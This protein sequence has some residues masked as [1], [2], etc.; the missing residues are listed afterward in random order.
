MDRERYKM[1][2]LTKE[3][4]SRNINF[5]QSR[6]QSKESYQREGHYISL[7]GQFSTKGVMILNMCK[8]NIRNTP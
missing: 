4:R 1:L 2:T 8:L 7:K 6:F 5:R 3:S